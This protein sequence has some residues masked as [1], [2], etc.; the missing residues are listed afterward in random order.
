M[1]TVFA[2]RLFALSFA[3]ICI[4]TSACQT[5]K[6]TM[7]EPKPGMTVV[8]RACYD[9]VT[10]VRDMVTHNDVNPNRIY[11][12]HKCPCCRTDMSVYRENGVLMVKCGGCAPQGVACDKCLPPDGIAK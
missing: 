8:C 5:D 2:R 10:S 12:E 6:H 7:V 4:G 9:E 1:N 11:S 3:L